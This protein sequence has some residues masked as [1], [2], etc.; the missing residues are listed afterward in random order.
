[1]RFGLIGPGTIAAK[2]AEAAKQIDDVDLVRIASS[3]KERAAAFAAA[4]GIG[5]PSTYDE[6]LEDDSI[7]AVYISVINTRHFEMT[8]RCLDAGKAVLCEK[9][10]CPTPEEEEELFCL[11]DD[12]HLLLMEGLWTLFLPCIR[13]AKDWTLAG[14]IGQLSFLDS[15]FCFYNR[16]NP[17]GRLFDQSKAGGGLYDVGIYTLA[18]S[19]YMTGGLPDNI[20][21]ALTT[22][23]TGV[24][25]M[26]SALLSF[27]GGYNAECLFGVQG[28]VYDDAHIA[29]TDGYIELP[30]F[31]GAR[32]AVLYDNEGKEAESI[33]DPCENGFI[34]E[35]EAFR[36]AWLAGQT[37]VTPATHSLSLNLANIMQTIRNQS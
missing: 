26:G 1:M 5:V 22:G 19:L 10:F 16:T 36:D 3:K 33:E 8:K 23:R 32:R 28:A 25:T 11:A 37:E 13:K 24:D 4:H 29:G 34:Y 30:H 17:E 7:D 9:P 6:L 20:Q 2:F 14:R 12:N 35:I 31:W 27:P 15:A 18:F 21:S